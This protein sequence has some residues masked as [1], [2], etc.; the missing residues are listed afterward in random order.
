MGETCKRHGGKAARGPAKGAQARNPTIPIIVWR[1]KQTQPQTRKT[2]DT[3]NA[4]VMVGVHHLLSSCTPHLQKR[5]YLAVQHASFQGSRFQ[6]A[7][8][9]QG[10]VGQDSKVPLFQH[11]KTRPLLKASRFFFI[12]KAYRH[13]SLPSSK[14]LRLHGGS[15]LY[16][17]ARARPWPHRRFGLSEDA[18]GRPSLPVAD[19]DSEMKKSWEF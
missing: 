4:D 18:R 10:S 9:F 19:K 6:H 7:T 1:M 13:S 8:E 3:N 2:E 5:K 16:Q 17:T 11:S 15:L 14:V 12:F